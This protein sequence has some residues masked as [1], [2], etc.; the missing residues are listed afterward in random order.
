MAIRRSRHVSIESARVTVSS[1]IRADIVNHC[2][3]S[4][5]FCCCCFAASRFVFSSTPTLLSPS[6]APLSA[7]PTSVALKQTELA[8][9]L[10]DRLK[11][12][13]KQ[14]GDGLSPSIDTYGAALKYAL[15][16]KNRDKARELVVMMRGDG[17]IPYDI[18]VDAA[19]EAKDY[20]AGFELLLEE[21]ANLR[22]LLQSTPHLLPAMD[23]PSQTLHAA[24][25]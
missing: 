7:V 22:S 19:L 9:Q 16:S 8:F 4:V 17:L 15:L 5:S 2:F 11:V 23:S 25:S 6:I 13:S 24:F 20:D 21:S 12:I 3:E 1:S 18:I 14:R 10:T